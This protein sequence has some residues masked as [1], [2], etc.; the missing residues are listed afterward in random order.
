LTPGQWVFLRREAAMRRGTA[1]ELVAA[2]KRRAATTR[3]MLGPPPPPKDR[4]RKCRLPECEGS[5]E[6]LTEPYCRPHWLNLQSWV[7]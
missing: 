6:E 7:V 2:A 4:T 5:R 3:A 1:T